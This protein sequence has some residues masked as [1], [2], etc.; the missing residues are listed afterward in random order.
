MF[1]RLRKS[2]SIDVDDVIN[3]AI[4]RKHRRDNASRVALAE[5]LTSMERTTRGYS[6]PTSSRDRSNATGAGCSAKLNPASRR[7]NRSLRAAEFG[8][9]SRAIHLDL[10]PRGPLEALVARQ[11]ARS[12]WRLQENLN[13]EAETKADRAA[14]A[15]A[16]AINTLDMLQGRRGEATETGL[17]DDDFAT[18]DEF[19]PNEWPVVPNESEVLADLDDELVKAEEPEPPI[20]RGRLIYD[21][22]VSDHSPV[23]KGTWITVS[24]VVSLIVDG[25]T[26]A[27]ILR[28]HPELCEQ[29]IRLCVAY[30]IAE[31]GSEI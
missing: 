27:D 6:A 19:Q 8:Q 3:P 14:R 16:V 22:D 24:H 12:A 31:E 11:A 15:L 9:L 18:E 4:G 10:N 26:W 21:F 13:D 2:D 28:T 30:A 20:W 5:G 7:V 29:D 23:I 25:A 1:E 17:D